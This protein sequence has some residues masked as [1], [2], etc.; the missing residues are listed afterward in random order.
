MD[1]TEQALTILRLLRCCGRYLHHHWGDGRGSQFRALRILNEQ[2][3]LTQRQL[4]DLM[5]IQQGSLS[6][7]VKKL[8]DQGFI[9]REREPSDRRQ[10]LIRATEEGR[11]Q[12]RLRQE[13]RRRESQE[14]MKALNSAEQ[15]RLLELLTKLLDSWE[16]RDPHNHPHHRP[17]P[18]EGGGEG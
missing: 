5:E 13:K 4:Q 14:L 6:E 18:L 10:L 7:I 16:D 1:Q 17:S 11:N 9:A 3:Q 12:S 15:E 2:G 8:E